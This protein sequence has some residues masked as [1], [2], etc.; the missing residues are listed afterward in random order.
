MNPK[1]RFSPEIEL[2]IVNKYLSWVKSSVLVKEYKFDRK[3]INNLL[4]RHWLADVTKTRKWWREKMDT[5]KIDEEIINLHKKWLSQ[6]QIGKTV[7]ISQSVISRVIKNK[8]LMANAQIRMRWR[9]S[10]WWKWWVI[11]NELWYI[12]THYDI[13]EGYK[14]MYNKSWY[15]LEHR[16]VMAK[17]LWRALLRNETVHHIDWNKTNNEINNLQLRIWQHGR[18]QVYCCS[19]CWSKRIHPIAL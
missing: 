18:W 6:A 3:S 1:K 8:W 10:Q 13:H 9:E 7:W 5:S 19:E 14:E 4:K 17:Y 16:I 12:L 15:A 2:E 11:K